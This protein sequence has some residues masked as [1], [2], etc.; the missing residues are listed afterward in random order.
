MFF[1]GSSC[2]VGARIGIVLISPQGTSYEF[3]I[4]IEKISTNNQAEYQEVLKGIKLLREVN[5]EVIEIV[6]DSQLM[7]N[8]LAG[9]YECK[10]DILRVSR[11]ECLQLLREFK[12]V[13]LE[14]IPKIH[15][16]EA[17]QLI[18][19]ASGYQ[20]ILTVGL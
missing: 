8:Q 18:Q 1:D 11:E 19:G 14:H 16:S 3:S 13:K 5:A 17:N 4:P 10:D 12:I 2:G 7:I 15:N 9:E 20:P 6:G